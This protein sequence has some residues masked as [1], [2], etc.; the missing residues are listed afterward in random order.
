MNETEFADL[1]EQVTNLREDRATHAAE[2]KAISTRVDTMATDVKTIL[3]YMERTKGSWKTLVVLGGLA[4]SIGA[5]SYK[6][7]GV[8]FK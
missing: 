4:A 7:L 5:L 2:I 3:G 6:F 1:R 8:F